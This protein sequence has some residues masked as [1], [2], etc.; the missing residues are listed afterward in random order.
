MVYLLPVFLILVQPRPKIARFSASMYT[1][2]VLF[3]ILVQ[4]RP[5][6]F[7]Q[8]IARARSGVLKQNGL[9]LDLLALLLN[10]YSAENIG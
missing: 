7:G 1:F 3:V 5:N 10:S 9:K 4:P 6:T 2:F 8:C